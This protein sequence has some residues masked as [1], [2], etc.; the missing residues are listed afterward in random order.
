MVNQSAGVRDHYLAEHGQGLEE[1]IDIDIERVLT[2][3][4][5]LYQETVETTLADELT[6]L[7]EKAFEAAYSLGEAICSAYFEPRSFERWRDGKIY[8][9]IGV[10]RV[11]QLR[12]PKLYEF[13]DNKSSAEVERPIKDAESRSEG[14]KK[15]LSTTYIAEPVHAPFALSFGAKCATDLL[16]GR[17]PDP[18]EATLFLTNAYATMLQRY[19]RSMAFNHLDEEEG[20]DWREEFEL[21]TSNFY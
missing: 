8:E 14:I 11:K 5:E 2:D 6:E 15:S 20:E 18:L 4:G 10:D 19:N 13:L 21:D 16:S 3:G 1:D 12:G 17:S 7:R 9:S